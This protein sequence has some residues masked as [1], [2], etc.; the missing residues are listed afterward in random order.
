MIVLVHPECPHLP[1]IPTF[2][3]SGIRGSE[4]GWYVFSHLT[5]LPLFAA[6]NR[7]RCH[8]AGSEDMFIVQKHYAP[9]SDN[10]SPNSAK[11]PY[12]ILKV[13]H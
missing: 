7:F 12:L 8:E 3:R 1:P 5:S 2:T 9:V 11:S 10:T 13:T 6:P 4:C